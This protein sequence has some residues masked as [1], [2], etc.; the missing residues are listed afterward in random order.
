M[1]THITTRIHRMQQVASSSKND[2][3]DDKLRGIKY[4]GQTVD[5]V[6]AQSQPETVHS[7]MSVPAATKIITTPMKPIPTSSSVTSELSGKRKAEDDAY[8]DDN[9]VQVGPAIDQTLTHGPRQPERAPRRT[10]EERKQELEADPWATS[11]TPTTVKCK[12][13]ALQVKM[14]SDRTYA[15]KDWVAHKKTC[16]G[17]VG[18]RLVRVGVIKKQK[19]LTKVRRFDSVRL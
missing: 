12:G 2:E 4:H 8:S 11:F 16:A 9:T 6:Q 1:I 7:P 19:L 13:C 10:E 17:I 3:I 14:N 18:K 5:Q 15:T